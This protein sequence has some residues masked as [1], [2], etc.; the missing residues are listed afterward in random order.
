MWSVASI[1]D[2]A[3]YLT[4][5]IT[6]ADMNRRGRSDNAD[7]NRRGRSDNDVLVD[8]IFRLDR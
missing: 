4:V 2:L 1:V 8:A 6:F 5:E 7:M 3:P